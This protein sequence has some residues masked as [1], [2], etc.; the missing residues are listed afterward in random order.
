[1]DLSELRVAMESHGPGWS[2]LLAG[3]LDPDAMLDEVLLPSFDIEFI[4]EGDAPLLKLSRSR[5]STVS[6]LFLMALTS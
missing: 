3:D 2:R 5:S 4:V 6:R 1:M